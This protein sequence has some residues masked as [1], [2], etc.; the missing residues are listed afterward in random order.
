MIRIISQVKL[1]TSFRIIQ[2]SQHHIGLGEPEVSI[3]LY[4]FSF[5][6]KYD[7]SETDYRFTE[8]LML[9]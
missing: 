6:I 7:I 3:S 2:L 8:A 4:T 5:R 1:Q 9:K